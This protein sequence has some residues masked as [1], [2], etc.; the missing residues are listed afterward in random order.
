MV[1]V[2]GF[3]GSRPTFHPATV[4]SQVSMCL[5]LWSLCDHH[6]QRTCISLS[7]KRSDILSGRQLT[8]ARTCVVCS[9]HYEIVSRCRGSDPTF[10]PATVALTGA[11]A[12]PRVL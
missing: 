11:C 1:N 2:S 4:N 9:G 10:H 5:V 7:W 3:L 8:L 12:V 6:G